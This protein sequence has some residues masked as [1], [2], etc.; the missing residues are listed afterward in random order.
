MKCKK[1]GNKLICIIDVDVISE[2]I[3]NI[4]YIIKPTYIG[5][6]TIYMCFIDPIEQALKKVR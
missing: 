2:V 1:I 4:R 6:R 3:A 5:A